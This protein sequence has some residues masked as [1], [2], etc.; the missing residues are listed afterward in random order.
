MTTARTSPRDE[1]LTMFR[2]VSNQP[3]MPGIRLMKEKSRVIPQRI[4]VRD[5]VCSGL[6]RK[7]KN[8]RRRTQ[9]ERIT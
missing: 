9:R 2:R 4:L 6:A 1:P 5:A 3:R 7:K 8:V